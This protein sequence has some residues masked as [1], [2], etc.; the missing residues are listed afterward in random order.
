MLSGLLL[1]LAIIGAIVWAMRRFMGKKFPGLQG[2]QAIR[3]LAS[4]PLGTRQSLLLAEVG[5]EV[6]LLS[7][8]DGGISLLTKVESEAALER[9]DFL[10]SFKPT[11]FE[12]ELRRELNV[13]EAEPAG[14]EKPQEKGGEGLSV[15]ERLDRLRSKSGPGA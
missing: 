15:S 9:L 3:V 4:R 14:E 6:Y 1:V 7:Q 8:S 13:E 11:R 10:F 12:S 2:G 5:G